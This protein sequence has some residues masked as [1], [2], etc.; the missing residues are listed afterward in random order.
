MLRLL[1]PGFHS[2]TL[3]KAFSALR[4]AVQRGESSDGK[5]FRRRWATIRRVEV[6]VQRFVER[7]LLSLLTDDG[8]LAGAAIGVRS[9]RSSTNR[10]DVELTCA[11]WPEQS[12][13]LTWE[14]RGRH[15]RRKSL[16][17][18]DGSTTW[19]KAIAPRSERPCRDCFNVPASR[20]P[21][22]RCP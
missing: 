12:A 6:D 19:N 8:F 4:R 17:R 14:Y 9:V 21:A 10:I 7:E 3:P 18:R 5:R 20:K 16:V 22:D 1:R 13:V 2:G 11:M 15:T